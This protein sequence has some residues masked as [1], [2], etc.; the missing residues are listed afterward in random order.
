MDTVTHGAPTAIPLAEMP[1]LE[2]GTVDFRRLA[3]GLV[4][5]RCN[6]AM[7]MAVEGLCGEGKRRIGYRNR[8]L[9]TVI[10]EITL[11]IPKMREGS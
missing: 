2:D 8:R 5:P 11:R 3:A 7:E 4:E 1:T 10:G 9:M 6:A